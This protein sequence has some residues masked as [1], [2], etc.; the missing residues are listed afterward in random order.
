M[1]EP[2]P[3]PVVVEIPKRCRC[4][5][6]S[7]ERAVPTAVAVRHAAPVSHS[8]RASDVIR[9]GESQGHRG[10]D[11]RRLHQRHHD[12]TTTPPGR[13]SRFT[14]RPSTS[15][16][17]S[18]SPASTSLASRPPATTSGGSSRG[19]RRRRA[20][21]SSST[22][23]FKPTRPDLETTLGAQHRSPLVHPRAALLRRHVHGCRR[24]ALSRKTTP[25]SWRRGS[26]SRPLDRQRHPDWR[27]RRQAELQLRR[28]RRQR[29]PAMG[30]H[31]GLRRRAQDLHPFPRSD[32]RS[33]STR[34]LRRSRAPATRSS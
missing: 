34:S 17:S 9:R 32:A 14:P 3:K 20:G 33:R 15:P 23:T 22:S 30:P 27:D 18:C 8:Q 6:S 21:P 10:A 31:A 2:P 4:P 7:S 11:A 13:C 12:L 24:L 5:G 25:P 26:S 19:R 29:P 1:K 28:R 16:T